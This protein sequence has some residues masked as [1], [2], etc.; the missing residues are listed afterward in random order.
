MWI[1]TMGRNELVTIGT[2]RP[3]SACN[4]GNLAGMLPCITILYPGQELLRD[5]RA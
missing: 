4:I 5:E 1:W 3:V 2:G